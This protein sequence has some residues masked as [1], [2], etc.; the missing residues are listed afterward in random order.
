MT[1]KYLH[2]VWKHKRLPFHALTL[3]DGRSCE[4]RNP[5]TYNK[6]FAGPDFACGEVHIDGIRLF[7][8][9]EMHVR[10][11]D[12]NKHGHTDDPAYR[13]VIL[14]V[15]YEDDAPLSIDGVRV[16]TVELKAV[17]DQSHYTNYV[18]RRWKR[19]AFPCHKS[20]RD[21]LHPYLEMKKA[22]V[23]HEKLAE[24]AKIIRE[25]KYSDRYHVL[26]YC[27]AS[28]F[29]TSINKHG[30]ER[31]VQRVPYYSLK[32]LSPKGKYQLLMVESAI[33]MEEVRG[34]SQG[35]VWHRKGT[36]PA[37]SPDLRVQ[38]FAQMAA[39]CDFDSSFLHLS[40]REIQRYF[41]TLIDEIWTE[42]YGTVP[43]PSIDFQNHLLIN[44][45]VPFMWFCAQEFEDQDL[46]EK[47]YAV[48]TQLPPEQNGI[49]QKWRN[50]G[51]VPENA[52]DSQALLSLYRTHCS[53]KKCLSCDVGNKVLNRDR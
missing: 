4:I 28:A 39:R 37:N 7:G 24:K 48:L 26:Y 20:I 12:W 36:R 23:L 30:F 5:G 2:Y 15:V 35:R 29:G 17:L 32:G 38:Q 25:M 46:I 42:Q 41:R 8:S 43:K 44:A 50:I 21:L 22:S 33:W 10:S 52:Y 27:L 11:S 1:E 9:I 19:D 47:A 45:I 51:V 13:N 49:M 16:P 40:A 14:H 6:Q 18:L 3:T 34:V 31:L 53:R